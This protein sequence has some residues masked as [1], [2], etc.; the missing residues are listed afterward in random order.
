MTAT[1]A[2]V[3]MRADPVMRGRVLALQTM[4]F[5][6]STP[7]G[8]PV[9]GFIAEQFGARWSVAVGAVACLVA[10]TYGWVRTTRLDAA[11][12]AAGTVP[13]REPVAA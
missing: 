9:V 2:L 3:Q 4:V 1:T 12:P 6:G 7:I 8:G 11:G 13:P 10:G 5:L